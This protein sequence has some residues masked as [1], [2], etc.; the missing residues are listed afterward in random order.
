MRAF[1]LCV[2]AF[3]AVTACVSAEPAQDDSISAIGPV[4]LG[5][6]VGAIDPCVLLGAGDTKPEPEGEWACRLGEFR[7][8]ITD[9]GHQQRYSAEPVGLGG[10]KAYQTA[11]YVGGEPASCVIHVPL[12]VTVAT[13]FEYIPAAPEHAADHCAVLRAR[14]GAGVEVLA[15]DPDTGPLL[16]LPGEN[17]T[18]VPGACAD[19]TN[20]DGCEPYRATLLPGDP[21]SKLSLAVSDSHARCTLFADAVARIYGDAFAPVVAAGGCY[22]VRPDHRLQIQVMA[23]ENEGTCEDSRPGT[24]RV[25]KSPGTAIDST[26]VLVVDVTAHARRGMA[27]TDVPR[28]SEK[29]TERALAVLDHVLARHFA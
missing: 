21:A 8:A 1:V 25:C 28:V 29:D 16:Y 5:V 15:E 27:S 2:V 20:T 26:D 3:V 10:V 11:R 19:L 9:F 22:F 23:L 7:A 4:T 17:D 24:F 18:G 12:G 6:I 14:A 13:E